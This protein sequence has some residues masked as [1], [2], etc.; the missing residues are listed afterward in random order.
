[1]KKQ[2]VLVT[3]SFSGLGEQICKDL[4]EKGHRVLGYDILYSN[5]MDVALPRA[6][7]AFKAYDFSDGSIL[8]PERVDMLINCAGINYIDWLEDIT[9]ADFRDVMDTNVFGIIAM[10]QRLLPL[11]RESSAPGIINIVS[12]AAHV[13]MRASAVY[14]ASKGAALIL[15]RQMARELSGSVPVV[16][17]SPN[18]IEGT[19]MSAYI[20][21]KVPELRGWTPEEAERYLR[22]S[23]PAGEP[24]PKELVAR[25]VVDLVQLG[26]DLKFLTGTDIPVGA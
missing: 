24:T 8:E 23:L 6:G 7:S 19:R 10:T 20:R 17:V 3:G 4:I 11:L 2:T 14:N 5:A 9:L 18:F 15:S 16:S 13:P 22:A 26:P 12:N 25:I 21:K 1:M